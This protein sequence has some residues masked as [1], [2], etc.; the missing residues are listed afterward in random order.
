VTGEKMKTIQFKTSNESLKPEETSVFSGQ[1]QKYKV[2]NAIWD[3]Y[4][5]FLQSSSPFSKPRVLRA[6]QGQSLVG[7]LFYVVC[8]GTGKS[9]FKNSSLAGMVDILKIPIHVW[10][11][12]GIC[13]DIMSNHGFV[14]DGYDYQNIISGMLGH[15]R[16]TSPCLVVT[17]LAENAYLHKGARN[18]PYTKEGAISL[19]GM[20][21]ID[22]YLSDHSNLR[23]KLRK[24]T[25]DGGSIEIRAG[26]L[27]PGTM[28]IVR[29]CVLA[30]MER[31]V[32]RTP[33][34]DHFPTIILQTCC[35]NSDRIVHFIARMNGQ[36]LG[37]HTFIHTGKGLR[38]IHG[39]FDRTLETTQH[40]Y[41]NIIT[42]AADYA[43]KHGL[44]IVYF[45]PIMN[46]TK[47]RLMNMAF[48]S[49]VYL[50][51]SNPVLRLIL[52]FLYGR[53]RMQAKK[54]LEFS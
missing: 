4:N 8:Y 39:A 6:Y 45:G 33:F 34:Q 52:P 24:F 44:E 5:S 38:L 17:D 22:D 35:L 19:E 1:L 12:Q 23:K 14:A 3:I 9:L 54:F 25:K 46:E 43:L 31:S 18:F 51:C 15:L 41:E 32:I 36:F 42:A 2:D 49:K 40:S 27:D 28:E 29:K 16:Q 37:Y 10:I 26:S 11:R 30:T 50:Y 20:S 7:V 13:A 48:E 21:S 53:S 47:N